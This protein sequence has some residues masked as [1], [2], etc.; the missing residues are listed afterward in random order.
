MT[1]TIE[2]I[3]QNIFE[4]KDHIQH[5]NNK[6]NEYKEYPSFV[7]SHKEQIENLEP[8]LQILEQI[9]SELEAWEV[10]KNK[11]EL[12][13][14]QHYGLA[15]ETTTKISETIQIRIFVNDQNQVQTIIK[16]VEV[17]ESDR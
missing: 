1:K 7:K 11:M 17:E 2:F 8:I 13:Q 12:Y 5:L 4:C 10:C 14:E 9:K 15:K 3:N 6:I 16:A